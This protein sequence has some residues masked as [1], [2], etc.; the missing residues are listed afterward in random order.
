VNADQHI[1]EAERLAAKVANTSPEFQHSYADLARVH[2][3]IAKFHADLARV[4]IEIAKFLV[5]YRENR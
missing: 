3:E 1:V 4:H 5:L 2:I